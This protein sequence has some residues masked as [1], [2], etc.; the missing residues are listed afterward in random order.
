[1]LL[2][3]QHASCSA[4]EHACWRHWQGAAQCL[5]CPGSA[6]LAAAQSALYVPHLGCVSAAEP[7]QTSM[8]ASRRA[9]AP[10]ALI[11]PDQGAY[12]NAAAWRLHF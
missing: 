3:L 9:P 5:L 1:V 2:F 12:D 4:E 10:A 11:A 7:C 6:D 8:V